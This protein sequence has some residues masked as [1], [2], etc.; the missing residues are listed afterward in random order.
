[1]QTKPMMRKERLKSK[2]GEQTTDKRRESGCGG[3][4]SFAGIDRPDRR[5]GR[6]VCLPRAATRGRP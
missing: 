2:G 4:R 5:R 1:L 3:K 6:L